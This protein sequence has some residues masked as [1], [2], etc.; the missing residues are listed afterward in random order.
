MTP[1]VHLLNCSVVTPAGATTE[2]TMC[3]A[4]KG[5]DSLRGAFMSTTVFLYFDLTDVG[6]AAACHG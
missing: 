4:Q 6:G 3:P 2:G 5:Q 1:L